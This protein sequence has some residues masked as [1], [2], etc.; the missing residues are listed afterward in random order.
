MEKTFSGQI[1]CSCA[2]GAN[3]RSY[4]KQRARYGTPFLQPPPPSAGVHPPPPPPAEQFSG[5]PVARALLQGHHWVE[6]S[7]TTLAPGCAPLREQCRPRVTPARVEHVLRVHLPP[8]VRQ[9][10]A[11]ELRDVGA[12]GDQDHRA[13]PAG[14]A[15]RLLHQGL[16]QHQ[17]AVHLQRQR[18]GP[19]AWQAQ[20]TTTQARGA[21]F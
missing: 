12:R 8:H 16:A 13:G 21:T 4:T 10:H 2:F 15:V 3:I 6:A 5:C 9:A 11:H 7:K 18:T 1:L 17:R 14:G 19:V 20:R